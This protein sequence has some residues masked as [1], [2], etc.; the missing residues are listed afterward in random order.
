MARIT[1]DG[2]GTLFDEFDGVETGAAVESAA[3]VGKAPWGDHLVG[4]ESASEG[5][6]QRQ[7]SEPVGD[8]GGIF[9]RSGVRR[10][11]AENERGILTWKHAKLEQF[12]PCP[13]VRR[14]LPGCDHDSADWAGAQPAAI[15]QY[16]GGIGIVDDQEPGLV[17]AV[18]VVPHQIRG[19]A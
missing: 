18:K 13:P 6:C 1:A 17:R 10:K 4:E 11:V 19:G 9:D 12:C 14:C 7:S 16:A 5:E 15:A 3:V 2:C 8:L